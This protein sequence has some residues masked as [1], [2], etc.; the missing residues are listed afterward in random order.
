MISSVWQFI[1]K[2]LCV[3]VFI[4]TL[5]LATADVHGQNFLIS[6]N[7]QNAIK[8]LSDEGIADLNVE[9]AVTP[10]GVSADS[11]ENKVYWSNV[12]EGS[13]RRANTDGTNSETVLTELDVPRGVAV[14]AGSNK[15]FWAEAG[16]SSPA[17]RGVDLGTENAAVEDI[18]TTGVSSPYH[19][20]LD[21]ESQ[22]IYW[23]DNAVDAKHIK[24][25]SYDGTTVE[26]VISEVKQVSGITLDVAG[27]RIFWGD[28]EDD[29]IYSAS[30]TGVDS[31][32]QTVHTMS[33]EASPWALQFDPEAERLLWSDYLTGTLN[34]LVLNTG[35]VTNVSSSAPS[36][37]GI[38]TYTLSGQNAAPAYSGGSGTESDPYEIE[39]WEHLHNVR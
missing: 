19:I 7:S 11:D 37:S 9:G 26:T 2:L 36:V 14:D 28:F 35:T 15:L 33:E 3:T 8:V 29:K 24:R 4:S 23:V 38:S 27:D 17:I 31:N 30:T 20:A 6:S 22:H 13:I 1:T 12:T 10:W 39:T 25:A 18:V 5:F 34:Q 32:I 21:S 16:S